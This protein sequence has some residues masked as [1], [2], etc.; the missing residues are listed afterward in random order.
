[1]KAMK[2]DLFSR[3]RLKQ[4]LCIKNGEDNKVRCDMNKKNL[5]EHR[6][7]YKWDDTPLVG[8]KPR[9]WKNKTEMKAFKR[10]KK[11]LEYQNRSTI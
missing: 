8:D 1:M 3:K 2:D 11:K 4:L 9:N 10:K 6:K 7:N 5:V